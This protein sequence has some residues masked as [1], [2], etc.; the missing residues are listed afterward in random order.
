[1][2]MTISS[3]AIM[4]IIAKKLT[5]PYNVKQNYSRPYTTIWL[6]SGTYKIIHC[7]PRPNKTAHKII[8]DHKRFSTLNI[9]D[10]QNIMS[11]NAQR[12]GPSEF[13]I[14]ISYV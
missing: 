4:C 10:F 3:L 14:K 5:K 12:F 1:M 6:L 9:F 13:L 8:Q 7:H 2:A 11:P